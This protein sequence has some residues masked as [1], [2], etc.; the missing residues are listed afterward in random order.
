MRLE[1]GQTGT[2]NWK[3][4]TS[5][6]VKLVDKE[7]YST[8]PSDY[9]FEYQEGETN[10]QLVHPD[11]GKSDFIKSE[12]VLPEGLI[13]YLFVPDKPE[14]AEDSFEAKLEDCLQK[15]FNDSEREQAKHL[16]SQLEKRAG[17]EYIEDNYFNK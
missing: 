4:G 14:Y 7:T 8:M 3:D 5:A 2:M 1:I 15:N 17:R 11:Y 16:F 9:W 12:I 6:K 13:D 10:K